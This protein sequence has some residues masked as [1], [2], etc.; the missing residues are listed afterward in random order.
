MSI[1][2]FA[3]FK[4]VQSIRKQWLPWLPGDVLLHPASS[5]TS[6]SLALLP[7]PPPDALGLA[8]T[9]SELYHTVP[10]LGPLLPDNQPS[11]DTTTPA[12]TAKPTAA[13]IAAAAAAAA[14]A[15][16][17]GGWHLAAEGPPPAPAGA[18]GNALASRSSPESL[19]PS[20]AAAA[21]SALASRGRPAVPPS[22]AAA[23]EANASAG[24][25]SL[26]ADTPPHTAAAACALADGGSDPAA[27]DAPPSAA[28]AAAAA[29]LAGGGGAP[30]AAPP[31][32]AA[33][34]ALAGKGWDLAADDSPPIPAAAAVGDLAGRG[35]LPEDMPFH[36]AAARS[37]PHVQT[38]GCC[39]H[40]GSFLPPAARDLP[41]ITPMAAP[42]MGGTPGTGAVT[43][44]SRPPSDDASSGSPGSSVDAW[45]WPKLPCSCQPLGSHQIPG[46]FQPA[47]SRHPPGS[48]QPPGSF[49]PPSSCQ[50]Q[51][52]YQLPGSC[53][54]WPIGGARSPADVASCLP[55]LA[56]PGVPL[57]GPLQYLCR[58]GAQQLPSTAAGAGA[59]GADGDSCAAS[60]AACGSALG[61][62]AAAANGA[63]V[64]PPPPPPPG[65]DQ[66]TW[67]WQLRWRK[68]AQP[69]VQLLLADAPQQHVQQQ[70]QAQQR[71]QQLQDQQQEQQ[72][73]QQMALPLRQAGP[74]LL[75]AACPAPVARCICQGP[76][77]AS[78]ACVFGHQFITCSTPLTTPRQGSMQVAPMLLDSMRFGAPAAAADGGMDDALETGRGSIWQGTVRYE[79]GV[80]P[81]DAAVAAALAAAAD[82]AAAEAAAAGVAAAA[83]AEAAQGLAAAPGT[84]G[85]GAAAEAAAAAAATA[86]EDALGPCAALGAA[87]SFRGRPCGAAAAAAFGAAEVPLCLRDEEGPSSCLDDDAMLEGLDDLASEDAWY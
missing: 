66:A 52:N 24:R 73:L 85:C 8:N 56:A 62:A 36:A 68:L 41:G 45:E 37:D 17:D 84:G 43:P 30:L 5:L 13:L 47:G 76:P 80:S 7:P 9:L 75:P 11:C 54:A 14:N 33:V 55:P 79:A 49:Q 72:Q 63:V 18:A 82:A 59:R 35:S 23:A 20:P 46:G 69:N 25:G 2:V 39:H 50:P 40:A 57:A 19:L 65:E 4:F 22:A 32:A 10:Y 31:A 74:Q 21:C 61:A 6:Q 67:Q 26:P 1:G 27:D 48:R 29:D 83:A 34:N 28:A 86:D 71:L 51:G 87:G 12:A 77:P 15:L 38:G 16:A 70:L 44:A 81:I 58:C 78:S 3:C 64:W 42:A 53:P 60:A